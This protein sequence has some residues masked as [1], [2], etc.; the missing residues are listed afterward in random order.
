MVA[1]AR[2]TGGFQL[3]NFNHPFWCVL[4]YENG[5]F[6]IEDSGIGMTVSRSASACYYPNDP[7]K[8]Q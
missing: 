1:P 3:M 6:G 8:L 2:Q 7:L 5:A 4:K